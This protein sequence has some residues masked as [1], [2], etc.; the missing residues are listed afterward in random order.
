MVSMETPS[1]GR[2]PDVDQP[3]DPQVLEPLMQ[4]VEKQFSIMAVKARTA[5]R[6]RA[7]EI[8]PELQ[9]LGYRV[10]SIL[11]RQQAQQQIVLASE[12]HVDK[13]T[14]S[15]TI[16]QLQSQGLVTREPDPSDGRA[17]LVSIT[18]TAREAWNASGARAR[19]LMRERLANWDP[20]E[21]RRFA[22]LLARLNDS[23]SDQHEG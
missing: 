4:E 20:S 6:K 7:L 8:H 17:M 2:T 13:A 5:I 3:A 15:R 19:S 18:D 10:L 21:I 9:P 22:D 11:V 16:K 14:M 12:L 23:E 1:S